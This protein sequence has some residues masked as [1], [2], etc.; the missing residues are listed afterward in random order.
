[1]NTILDDAVDRAESKEYDLRWDCDECEEETPHDVIGE[2]V[3]PDGI[4]YI[5][6]TTIACTD[7]GHE[8]D[9]TVTVSDD[10]R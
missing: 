6:D 2:N 1:M 10:P 5:I 7:C 4:D 3:T 9:V 8:H